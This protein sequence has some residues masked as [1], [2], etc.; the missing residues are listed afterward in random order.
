VSRKARASPISDTLTSLQHVLRRYTDIAICVLTC[1]FL[2][3]R[4]AWLTTTFSG[5]TPFQDALIGQLNQMGGESELSGNVQ[6]MDT[7][8]GCVGV[9]YDMGIR[10]STGFL[11]DCYLFTDSSQERDRYRAAFW[12]AYTA[13]RPRVL[14]VTNEFCFGR[15]NGF[16]K[17]SRWPQLDSDIQRNYRESIQWRSTT[18]VHYWKRWEEPPQFRI[19]V[20]KD[21][22]TP[23]QLEQH[24]SLSGHTVLDERDAHP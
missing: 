14:V 9:L 24:S 13:A 3:P 20:R 1:L 7:A 18:R 4:F 15:P 8:H 2:G 5:A 12:A 17:L 21:I 6:C 10:Q 22:N 19:F 16:V 11:Y 23:K